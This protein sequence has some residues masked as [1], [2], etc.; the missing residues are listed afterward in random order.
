M[1]NASGTATGVLQASV[2][3]MFGMNGDLSVGLYAYGLGGIG[4]P[5][6]TSSYSVNLTARISIECLTPGASLS[7]CSG[8]SYAP[9]QAEVANAGGGCGAGSPVLTANAPVLG[10]TQTFTLA[11]APASQPVFL[12]LALGDALAV[13]FGPCTV[14]VDTA[15]ASSNFVGSTNGIGGHSHGLAIPASAGLA[16]VRFVAQE[17]IL[18][19]GGPMLGA[20]TLSNGLQATV[21]L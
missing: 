19:P 21:G 9:L 1:N 15:G 16:G 5:P 11:A 2:G 17:L 10:Q 20:A 6:I 3:G 8:R 12:V 7:F 4:L 18:L 14:V 13:P